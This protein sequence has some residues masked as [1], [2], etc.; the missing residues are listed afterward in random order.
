MDEKLQLALS[1]R[2]PTEALVAQG[3]DP[4]AAR[5]QAEREFGDVDDARRYIGAMDR[6]TEAETRRR[7]DLGRDLGYACALAAQPRRSPP[8]RC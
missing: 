1:H 5:R 2:D 3:H 6:R 7:D 8:S 4:A